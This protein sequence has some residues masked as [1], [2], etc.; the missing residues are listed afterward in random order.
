MPI[1]SQLVLHC[2]RYKAIQFRFSLPSAGLLDVALLPTL[3]CAGTYS[4][5]EDDLFGKTSELRGS[6]GV[7]KAP[8][9]GDG[10]A[11]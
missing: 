7:S 6:R 11:R 1:L 3:P 8:R 10:I 2:P 5:S 4:T 9:H